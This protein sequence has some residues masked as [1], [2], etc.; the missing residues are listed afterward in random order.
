MIRPVLCWLLYLK[1]DCCYLLLYVVRVLALAFF[2][3]I[4]VAV[5]PLPLP[6]FPVCVRAY[7]R[8]VGGFQILL[9]MD[10]VWMYLSWGGDPGPV[11]IWTYYWWLV[12]VVCVLL[13][14]V[15]LW[16]FSRR[17]APVVE[18]ERE[19]EYPIDDAFFFLFCTSVS[20]EDLLLIL[21][22]CQLLSCWLLFFGG[23]S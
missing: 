22:I 20:A 8:P 13:I 15:R 17:R 16:W 5:S 4:L 2:Y 7:V 3:V 6:C 11:F 21:E 14:H 23:R 12:A 10:T 19:R 9:K 1:T 18:R